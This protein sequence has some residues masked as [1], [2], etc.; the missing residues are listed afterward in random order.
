L[1]FFLV[2][3]GPCVEVVAAASPDADIL[4]TLRGRTRWLGP[5]LEALCTPTR[6][7]H[8]RAAVTRHHRRGPRPG[9][10]LRILRRCPPPNIRII[11]NVSMATVQCG[12]HAAPRVYLGSLYHV[13]MMG[14][15]MRYG[16][17][18]LSTL[19]LRLSLLMV[20]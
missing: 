5:H 2:G 7:T 12:A 9:Q 20:S 11:P 13:H 4:V 8:S 3:V 19:N 18:V 1:V 10:I 17:T 15:H 16:V 6:T 14:Q